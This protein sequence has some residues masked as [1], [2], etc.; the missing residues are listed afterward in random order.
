MHLN[1]NVSGLIDR[2]AN[3]T[4]TLNDDNVE[5]LK[6]QFAKKKIKNTYFSS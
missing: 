1:C 6:G 4:V 2:S 3:V 5:K